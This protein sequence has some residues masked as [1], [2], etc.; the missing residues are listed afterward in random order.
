MYSAR[1]RSTAASALLV[2]I[3]RSKQRDSEV[4][5]EEELDVD[6][7]EYDEESSDEIKEEPKKKEVEIQ[8]TIVVDGRSTMRKTA[9]D[10]IPK[11][12]MRTISDSQVKKREN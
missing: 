7:N 4:D 5:D 2:P 9:H 11:H 3:D 1:L 8:K 6:T 12:I 10:Y